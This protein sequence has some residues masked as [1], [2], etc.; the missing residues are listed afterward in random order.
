MRITVIATGFNGEKEKP[1]T[2]TS[3]K[4]VLSGPPAGVETVQ[5]TTTPEDPLG[6][7]PM[8]PELDIPDFLQ[9]RRFPRR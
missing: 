1:Q 3:T 9:K 4:T 5:S 6:E 7:I 8:A 2:K